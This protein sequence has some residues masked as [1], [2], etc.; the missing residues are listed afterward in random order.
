MS[1]TLTFITPTISEF[2]W[3][4]EV[5]DQLLMDQ[6][7]FDSLLTQEFNAQIQET[8]L[9]FKT[10]S[11]L[12][13]KAM[14][15]DEIEKLTNEFQPGHF[16]LPET[17]W[18]VPVSYS[19]SHGRDLKGLAASKNI[20]EDEF[21]ALHSNP[22]YRIHFYG[23][24]PGFMYLNGLPKKLITPR[25]KIPDR[26]IPPGS[27]A[28]GASQTGIYPMESP[29]GWHL[30]GRSPLLFFNVQSNPPVWAKPGERLK[31][32]PISEKEFDLLI[33]HPKAA[34]RL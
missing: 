29:G 26:S 3:D 32:T 28:I 5:S 9:G 16:S 34:R 25:K 20:S 4:Q 18:E 21:I 23:F 8:R 24:L 6:L 11:V 10:L 22:L 2:Y 1:P 17:L 19:H 7:A 33:R 30:I 12:W 14:E 15:Q 27:V 13:K 31:F